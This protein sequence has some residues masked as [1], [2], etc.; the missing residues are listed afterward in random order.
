MHRA[1]F[2][3]ISISLLSLAAQAQGLSF[4][5]INSNRRRN[6]LSGRRVS[7]RPH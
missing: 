5:S 4:F 2:A 7:T 3:L 6:Y 1:T